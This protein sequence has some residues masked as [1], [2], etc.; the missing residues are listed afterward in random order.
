MVIYA[1]NIVD[2]DN[3]TII[4]RKKFGE[5]RNSSLRDSIVIIP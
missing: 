2:L 1:T 3:M 5:E 4:T